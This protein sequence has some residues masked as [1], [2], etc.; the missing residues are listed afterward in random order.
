MIPS[1]EQIIADLLSGRIV[2]A[3]A[4]HLIQKYI[5][6]A[7]LRDRFAGQAMQAITE[8]TD[9]PVKGPHIARIAYAIADAMLAER[10]Q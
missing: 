9:A 1:L 2:K 8:P 5:D 6:M 10:T 7:S 3:E 4:I